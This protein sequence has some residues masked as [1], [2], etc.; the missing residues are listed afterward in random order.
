MSQ[1][2]SRS[3]IPTID[4]DRDTR[5]KDSKNVPQSQKAYRQAYV[6]I[7]N[8]CN[9]SCPG[10]PGHGARPAGTMT[11][12]LFRSIARQIAPLV[13]KVYLHVLGEPLLH[14]SFVEIIEVCS[15][16]ALPVGITTN[17]RC[18]SDAHV[19]TLLHPIIRQVNISLHNLVQDNSVLTPHLNSILAFT[20]RAFEERPDLYINYRFWKLR[21]ADEGPRINPGHALLDRIVGELNIPNPD[22]GFMH[23]KRS[24]RLLNRLYLNIDSPFE[25]P[26]TTGD[27]PPALRGTC[28]GM[29]SQFGVLVDGTVVP[30]CLD[31]DGAIELGNCTDTPVAT[32]LDSDRARSIADGFSNGIRVEPFCQTCSFA[33]RFPS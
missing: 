12:E 30:C 15:E 9:H 25:W 14:P 23:K 31:F 13:E 5:T 10:C 11:V 6:E 7:I 18:M 16:E 4:G 2:V 29:R 1:T 17:G 3:L 26:G 21:D 24:Q 8:R 19:S 28:H 27:R 33:D 32:I 20:K 22:A